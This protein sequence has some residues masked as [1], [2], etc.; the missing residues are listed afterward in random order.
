MSHPNFIPGPQGILCSPSPQRFLLSWDSSLPS[1]SSPFHAISP[2]KCSLGLQAVRCSFL[3]FF[4]TLHHFSEDSMSFHSHGCRRVSTP[5]HPSRYLP[6][7]RPASQPIGDTAS[8]LS[9]GSIRMAGH[10]K[11]AP[12]IPSSACD[13]I[14][15]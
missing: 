11:G 4:R 5:E 13:P 3:S 6:E 8:S 15:R 2:M 10:M 1:L 14:R 9:R 7:S 12:G